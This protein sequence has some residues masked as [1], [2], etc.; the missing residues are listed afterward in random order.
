MIAE[1]NAALRDQRGDERALPLEQTLPL[2]IEIIPGQAAEGLIDIYEPGS[3]TRKTLSQLIGNTLG[4]DG[5]SL[6]EQ[7]I[8]VDIMRQLQ[9]G[10][11]LWRGQEIQGLATEY[12][13]VE[14]T[15]DG[16][17]YLYV[18]VRVIKPQEGGGA[19][20]PGVLEH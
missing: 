16:E 13:V 9:G 3:Y 2:V 17:Q 20:S 11:I 10:K 19:G 15:D 7:Q 14:R 6:E 18:P 4:K 12:A 5:W 8:L 1:S